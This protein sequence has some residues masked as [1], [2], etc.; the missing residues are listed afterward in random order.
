MGCGC[1]CMK[2]KGQDLESFKVGETGPDGYYDMHHT[3]LS[4]GAHFDHLDGEIF[5]KCDA[6][7]YAGRAE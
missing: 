6:C 7:G 5:G 2:C 3:C 1:R 4:C